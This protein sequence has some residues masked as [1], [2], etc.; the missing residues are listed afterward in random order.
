FGD[1]Q[2]RT[3]SGPMGTSIQLSHVYQTPG[4]YD[5]RAVAFISGQAQAAVYDRY[6]MVH[7]V[8]RRFSVEVG[9]HVLTTARPR[10]ARSYLAPQAVI[11]VVPHIGPAT[12]DTSATAFRH[13]DV[14]RGALTTLSVHLLIM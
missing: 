13:V 8:H 5:A 3:L 1:G 14:L 12:D 9:N 2:S 6:G 7:L 4:H 11:G 10:P